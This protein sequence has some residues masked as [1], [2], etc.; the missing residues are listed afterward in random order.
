MPY[1]RIAVVVGLA[2][3]LVGLGHFGPHPAPAGTPGPPASLVA[4]DVTAAAPSRVQSPTPS[5]PTVKGIDA[6]TGLTRVEPLPSQ[7]KQTWLPGQI[8]SQSMAVVGLILYYIVD[9]DRIQSTAVGG[10]GSRQTLAVAPHCKGIN[11][12]AAAGNELAYVVTSPGGPTAQVG[13]CGGPSPVAWSVWLL[14]LNGGSPRQVASG[15]REVTSIDV[16]EFPIHLAL[17]ESSYAFDRPPSSAA[18][19]PGETVEVHSIEGRLLWSSQTQTP[20]SDVM[21]GGG[22][23]A[24]LTEDAPLVEGLLDLWVSDAGH[25]RPT[26]VAQPGSS[27]SLSPDGSY[28]TWDLLPSAGHS[29]STRQSTVGIA[30]LDSGQVELL[31]TLTGSDTPEPLDPTVSST[32]RGP[33]VA[34]FATAPGGTVYPAFRFAASAGGAVLPSLQI[35]VWMAI[36]GNTLTWVAES[37]D[38]WSKE[39][40]AVDLSSLGLR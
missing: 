4:P 37:S 40:F 32:G 22:R 34:W 19:G 18:D 6:L 20:V 31:T 38:D 17:T 29:T 9:G 16:A 8:T 15:V 30:A 27:A 12:L 24:I 3:G 26:R 1:L 7:I 21:L 13:A 39:V 2:A 10:N 28:L 25:P 33:V 23:L 36:E 35:P 11:E 14:D 5:G